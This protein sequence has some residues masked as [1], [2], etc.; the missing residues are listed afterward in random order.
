M[1]RKKPRDFYYSFC[2]IVDPI[3]MYC[4]PPR[5]SLHYNFPL[6]WYIS[7]RCKIHLEYIIYFLFDCPQK[8]SGQNSSVLLFRFPIRCCIF[9]K[10]HT[11][12]FFQDRQIECN[13]V[14]CLDFAIQLPFC[15]VYPCIF[16]SI[17]T[18]DTVCLLK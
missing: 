11:S 17:V 5:G 12:K 15:L 18:T 6:M 13:C 4:I 1:S 9:L 10:I 8:E 7:Y 16:V 14:L 2:L 3:S